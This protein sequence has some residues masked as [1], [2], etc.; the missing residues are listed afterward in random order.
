MP[1][2]IA[3]PKR[4]HVSTL[5]IVRIVN[6]KGGRRGGR[7]YYNYRTGERNKVDETVCSSYCLRD[8]VEPSPLIRL[9]ILLSLTILTPNTVVSN[10]VLKSVFK[11]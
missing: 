6:H 11:S 7:Q 1:D 5:A 4:Q 8:Y 2:N 9:M 3:Q 10:V